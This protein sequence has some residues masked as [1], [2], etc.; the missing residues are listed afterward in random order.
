MHSSFVNADL[1]ECFLRFLP[2]FQSLASTILT[3]KAIYNVFQQHPRSVV[4]SV[5]YNLIGPALP[6]ALRFVRCKNAQLYYKPVGEL[7]GEDDIQKNPVLSSEDI[8]SLVGIST[9]IQELESL[10]SWR[11]F[12]SSFTILFVSIFC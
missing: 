4:R 1:V 11:Y 7:L 2:D 12:L 9:S 3:S 10:F 5:A 6:Q 8:T